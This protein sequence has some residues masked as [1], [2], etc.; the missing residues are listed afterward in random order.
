MRSDRTP[1][2][3]RGPKESGFTLIELMVVVVIIGLAAA[4]VVLA[5]PEQ[6]GSVQAEA[7][8]FAV[9]AKAARDAAIVEARPMALQVDAAGYDVARR[10]GGEWEV[11]ARHNWAEGTTV[12]AFGQSGARI[13]FDS[14]G[15][16]GPLS[17]TLQRGERRIAVEIGHDGNV[18]VRR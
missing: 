1:T 13:R 16:A 18:H 3:R 9:R 15:L 6:G 10:S 7:E 4:A 14:T 5:V 8:R 17:L 12:E 11:T 2:V